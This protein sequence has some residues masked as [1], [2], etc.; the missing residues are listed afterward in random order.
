MATIV[1]LA[2]TS[3]AQYQGRPLTTEVYVSGK[4]QTPYILP[5]VVEF[6]C[7]D[8]TKQCQLCSLA[9]TRGSKLVVGAK[10]KLMLQLL[11]KSDRT[12]NSVL[13][14]WVGACEACEIDI[15]DTQNVEDLTFLPF[16]LL[17]SM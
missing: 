3:K 10:T 6:D 12:L 15:V 14:G 2:D 5:K 13:R 8:V 1:S 11:G 17:V 4:A 16:F 9:E 7:S